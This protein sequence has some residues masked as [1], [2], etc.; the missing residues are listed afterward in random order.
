ML[1]WPQF[2][3]EQHYDRKELS[4][5]D[6]MVFGATAESGGTGTAI[7]GPDSS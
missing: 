1:E 4:D 7:N 2:L 3:Q 5:D 6:G